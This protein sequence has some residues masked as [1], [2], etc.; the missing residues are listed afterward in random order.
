MAI[1]DAQQA[2]QI[3][4]KKGGPV[5]RHQLA[6]KRKDGKRP[7]YYG[8]D[9]GFGDDDY[10]DAA[11]ASSIDQGQAAGGSDRDF[12]RARQ[13][14]DNRAAAAANAERQRK[15][16]ERKE[17]ERIKKEVEKI[18]KNIEAKKAKTKKIKDFITADDAFLD[19]LEDDEQ[20]L[21]DTEL[22]ATGKE[23]TDLKNFDEN[24]DGKL[25]PLE[26]LN[27]IRTETAK[28][29]L[30]KSA[31]QKL[32][33]MPKSYVPSFFMSD[34]MRKT[35]PGVT[36]KGLDEI[37]GVKG[38][39]LKTGIGSMDDPFEVDYSMSQYGLKGKD[40]TRARNQLDVA[41]QDRIS[42]DDFDRV[43]GNKPPQR[44]DDRG[45]QLPIIPIQQPKDDKDE[46]EEEPFKLALAFRKD[47]GRVP[48]EDGGYTG[49]IMDL[50]TGR[51]MYFLGKL[52]KK[53]TRAV[54]KIVKSPVGK[55]GLGALAFKFGAPFLT[56]G[57]GFGGFAKKFGFDAIRK[58]IGE[59][60]IGKLAG[61]SIGGGLLAGA[62]A[63][64]GYKDEDG[65]GFDDKTGF[66][67]EEYRRRGAQGNVPIAFRAEGGM[68]DVENDPQY[69][70]WKRI[71]EVNP[72]AAE[73]HPKHKEFVK[74]YAS[75]ERQGKEEGGLM[76]LKGME[77]DFREDGGF[78]PIGKKERADDVP[79]RLSK[80]EFVMTADAVRGAG[81]G[82]IDKGAQKM[83]NL[84]SK[85]EAE[86][87]QSQGLDGAKKM[88]QTAQRLEEV[89]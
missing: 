68:S 67:V 74:Y 19:T 42:Q 89:L 25:G 62:L 20:D 3:M 71:Y 1:T 32:G 8:P 70:G 30:T 52:V 79:A 78:V 80:N 16:R 45:P 53:A 47:G 38:R 83:Y 60:S 41:M 51:Q 86:N 54:K 81:D 57:G 36:T 21:M 63:G 73:M 22:G 88:F 58:K 12:E 14:I 69:K 35:P 27:R 82:D 13:A 59:A 7:G 55:I 72:D 34:M 31:A 11:A 28:D 39:D 29:I 64:K 87:D 24:K 84:M 61:L 56:G 66:S 17:R 9:A 48:Y 77:M 6:K 46:E 43:Y 10:K 4:M 2:K 18:N 33:M 23:L 50:E 15:E 85:L 26:T 49:G 37:L 44:D 65:D 75:A 76:D 40:L 5:H